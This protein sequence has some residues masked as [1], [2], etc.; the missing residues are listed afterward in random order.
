MKLNPALN[1]YLHVLYV[2]FLI[3][4]KRDVEVK[5]IAFEKNQCKSN[6]ISGPL[7][8]VGIK[9]TGTTAISIATKEFGSRAGFF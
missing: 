8:V 2:S 3:F 6:Q 1:K 5:R 9:L 4:E 7:I